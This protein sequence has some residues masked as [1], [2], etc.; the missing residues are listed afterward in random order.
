M[1]GGVMAAEKGE[2]QQHRRHQ[3]GVSPT[4]LDQVDDQG[5]H[6]AAAVDEG[7]AETKR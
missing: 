2:Q 3:R 7:S 5:K 1:V 4:E 6:D